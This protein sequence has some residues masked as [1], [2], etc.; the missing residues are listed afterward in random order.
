MFLLCFG[1]GC[2]SSG[3]DTVPVSGV[4]KTSSGQPVTGVRIIFEPIEGSKVGATFGY[5]LDSGGRFEGE[6]FPGRYAYYLSTVEVQRDDDSSKPLNKK[7]EEKLN[8][9]KQVLRTMPSVYVDPKAVPQDH[10]VD[11]GAEKDVELIVSK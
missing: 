7:E 6:A 2:N 9:S 3:R 4:V 8:K 10:Q 11:L 5:D 1:I